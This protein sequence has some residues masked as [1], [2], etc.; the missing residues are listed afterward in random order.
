MI[1][2]IA[3]DMDETFL[4]SDKTYDVA[5]FKRVEK[6]LREQGVVFVIASGNSYDKLRDCFDEE[7]LSWIYLAGDNGNHILQGDQL[8]KTND[9][10]RATAIEIANY[11]NVQE[12]YYPII[13]TTERSYALESMPQRIYEHFEK[14]NPIMTKLPSFSEVPEAEHIV[15]IAIIGEK[16]LA[17]NKVMMQWIKDQ[18]ANVS[19]VTS[20]DIWLDVFH[21]QGGKGSA[22]AYFQDKY[23]VLPEETIAFGDS[24]NDLT[25]MQAVGYSV[26]MGNADPE[27]AQICRYQIG[28]NNDQAVLDVLE[29]IVDGTAQT[30][31]K[32]HAK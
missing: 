26:A 21:P 2:L 10:D 31:L 25:M 20:G 1:K 7:T 13:R 3:I 19:A 32:Q 24:L 15:K 6:Q 5:R 12:D 11:L 9:I 8:L 18:Y 28:T 30:L 23:N 14:Y 22:I 16:T 17:E 4:R 29:A 27:L